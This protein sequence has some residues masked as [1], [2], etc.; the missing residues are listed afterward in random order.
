MG[1][2]HIKISLLETDKNRITNLMQNQISAVSAI[3]LISPVR[4][5]HPE[6]FHISSS[7]WALKQTELIIILCHFPPLI[8]LTL[9]SVLLEQV[10]QP[11]ILLH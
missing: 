3:L 8:L 2:I 6:L 4:Y 1:K 7:L 9:L 5:T 11:A 10:R